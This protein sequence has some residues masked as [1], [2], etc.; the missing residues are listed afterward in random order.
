VRT[1]LETF[2]TGNWEIGGIPVAILI[3]VGAA[4]FGAAVIVIRHARGL[5]TPGA[6]LREMEERQ[7]AEAEANAPAAAEPAKPE[8]QAG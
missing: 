7:A 2:R 4:V 3:G 6:F 1:V 8:P 5:G